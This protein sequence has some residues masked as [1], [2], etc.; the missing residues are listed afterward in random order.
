[1]LI[2]VNIFI[3]TAS[4]GNWGVNCEHI[5]H[6][7]MT[8]VYSFKDCRHQGVSSNVSE[9]E[10]IWHSDVM[11][12]LFSSLIKP[13]FKAEQNPGNMISIFVIVNRI[14]YQLFGL[15]C[16]YLMYLIREPALLSIMLSMKCYIIMFN[17]ISWL[18]CLEQCW[19]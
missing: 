18:E 1:M 19:L 8:T 3:L 15:P 16:T 11:T 4:T 6:I 12:L 9:P 10:I 7:T 5:K 2:L 14:L 17:S 13:H